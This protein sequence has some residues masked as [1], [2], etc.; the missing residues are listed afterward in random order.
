MRSCAVAFIELGN[1]SRATDFVHINEGEW[2]RAISIDM[3]ARQNRN[4]EALQI[5]ETAHFRMGDL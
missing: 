5:T 2:A 4:Y 1:Y 3:L